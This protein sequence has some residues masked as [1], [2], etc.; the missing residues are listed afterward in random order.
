MLWLL[1]PWEVTCSAVSRRG[2]VASSALY[3]LLELRPEIVVEDLRHCPVALPVG[4]PF[5][6]V[7][8]IGYSVRR[9]SGR[10]FRRRGPH[11]GSE[12]RR[13][14]H[15][16]TA[17]DQSRNFWHQALV[18]RAGSAWCQTRLHS[19]DPEDF[20][21]PKQK[22][23]F[24]AHMLWFLTPRAQRTNLKLIPDFAKYP[25]LRFL[26]RWDL[27]P[28][29]VMALFLYAF[30][31]FVAWGMPDSGVTGWQ[32]VVWGLFVSTV[33][34]YHVTYIVNSAT[35]LIGTRR[36]ETKDDSRNSMIVALLTFGEGWHNNHHY[37]PNST[38]QGFFWWEIDITYYILRFM[39]MLYLVWDLKSVPERVLHPHPKKVQEPE[40]HVRRAPVTTVS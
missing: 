33:A 3:Q 23:I 12:A 1:L 21:S 28:P 27:L 2:Q 18:D 40:V 10:H 4:V 5:P 11:V 29:A 14:R 9:H 19:D 38:R 16:G 36:Y 25:E 20:H 35:H 30:G 22:G 34:V 6:V 8:P 15:S 32:L 31:E 7:V 13:G 39:S 37:Y 24:W 26:D 17:R